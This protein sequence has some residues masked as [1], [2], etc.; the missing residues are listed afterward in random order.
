MLIRSYHAISVRVGVL[1]VLSLFQRFLANDLDPV[2]IRVQDEGD[3][4]H[5][6]ISKLLLKLV[7]CILKARARSLQVVY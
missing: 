4:S 2:A 1:H 7:A 3:V 6:T 5:A